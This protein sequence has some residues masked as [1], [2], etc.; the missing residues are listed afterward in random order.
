LEH[1]APK[2]SESQKLCPERYNSSSKKSMTYPNLNR[3]YLL[4]T[5]TNY[6]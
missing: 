5:N 1:S 4:T 3:Y 6:I 2:S